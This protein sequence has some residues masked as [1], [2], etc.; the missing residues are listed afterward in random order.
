MSPHV[1]PDDPNSP[2]MPVI[3]ADALVTQRGNDEQ[4]L[5]PA[6]LTVETVARPLRCRLA[7]KVHP[8][9]R[10]AIAFAGSGDHI[11]TCYQDVLGHLPTWLEQE[12][13]MASLAQHSN[14]YTNLYGP[15]AIQTL[16]SCQVPNGFNTCYPRALVEF[17]HIPQLGMC[18]AIGSGHADLI[19]RAREGERDLQQMAEA[20]LFE[21]VRGFVASLNGRRLAE[22]MFT[23][24]NLPNAWGGYLEFVYFD[25]RVGRWVFGPSALNL[26]A[27]LHQ[28][29]LGVRSLRFYSRAIGYMPGDELGRVLTL[30]STPGGEIGADWTVARGHSRLT[31]GEASL[32]PWRNWIPETF[33]VTILVPMDDGS[34]RFMMRSN[35]P[36]EL[37]ALRFAIDGSNVHYGLSNKFAAEL[38]MA[39]CNVIQETFIQVAD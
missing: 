13:P 5:T 21:R 30:S 37:E 28:E 6:T 26:F 33:T 34:L 8:L 39:A 31:V 20:P 22:E 36:E 1:V 27:I 9:G 12:R 38:G 7:R 25:F 4:W 19:A 24:R 29:R 10:A 3:V 15:G 2:I 32:D 11:A 23:E 16:G 17:A 14:L 18:T 35:S